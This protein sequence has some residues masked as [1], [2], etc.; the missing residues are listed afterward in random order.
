MKLNEPAEI[1]FTDGLSVPPV[2]RESITEEQCP[3]LRVTQS[4]VL[5]S[6][7]ASVTKVA[8]RS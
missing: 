6:A 2:P 3:V 1:M 5:P 8:L 4:S 7:I